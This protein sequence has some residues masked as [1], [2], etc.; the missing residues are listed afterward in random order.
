MRFCSLGTNGL[1][2]R[3]RLH[4]HLKK[5]EV[6]RRVGYKFSRAQTHIYHAVH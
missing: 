6:K 2:N 5:P 1:Q 3:E 4:I